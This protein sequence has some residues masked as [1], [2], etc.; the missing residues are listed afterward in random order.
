[1]KEIFLT[2]GYITYVDDE[3]FEEL[4]VT[5]WYVLDSHP[6]IRYAARWQKP[7]TKPRIVVRMHHQVLKINP[8]RLRIEGKVID[9]I[10]RDGLNNQKANLRIATRSLN[11]LNS[12]R[13]D[14]AL[15][16]YFDSHRLK[17]KAIELPSKDFIGWFET[18]EDALEA[19][20]K[21]IASL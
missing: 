15:G 6:T 3:D 10:D 11:A 17:Y 19:K 5:P 16:I 9:H 20:N 18:F 2:R 7:I 12:E 1:M 4:N 14:N 13:S 8:L 21:R